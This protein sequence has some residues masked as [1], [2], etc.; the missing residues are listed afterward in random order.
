MKDDEPLHRLVALYHLEQISKSE[1]TELESRLR[2]S[3]EA[4]KVF[5]R[6][7]RVDAQLRQML[8]GSDVETPLVS[9]ATEAIRQRSRTVV[10]GLA[11]SV[12]LLLSTLAWM[13][14]S[15]PRAVATLISAENAA[16]ESSLPTTPGSQLAQ[17]SLKLIAGIATIRFD[18]GAEVVLE[19]PAQLDILSAMR[20]KLV[21]G[22]AVVD[23]P[24]TAIGFVMETPDS[25]AIDYGNRFAVQVDRA[26]RR[27][28]FELI[29]GEIAVHHAETGEELRMTEPRRTVSVHEGSIQFMDLGQSSNES[30]ATSKAIRIG[31]NG[32]ATSVLRNNK[33]R[34]FLDPEVLSVKKTN[35]GKWDQRSFFAFDLSSVDVSQIKAAWLRLNLVPSQRGFASRLPEVNRFG[36]YGLTN[37]TK[38]D[39]RIESTWEDAP[40]P[41][42]GTLLGTFEIA[43]SQQ[44][45]TFGIANRKVVEFLQKFPNETVHRRGHFAATTRSDQQPIL[46][47]DRQAAKLAFGRIVVDRDRTVIQVHHQ[48]VPLVQRVAN[49]LA[50]L[51]LGKHAKV[52]VLLHQ[53]FA[54]LFHDRQ[55]FP[56][57]K[58]KP[59][60]DRQR[61]GAIFDVIQATIHRERTRSGDPIVRFRFDELS[62]R[63]RIAARGKDLIFFAQINSFVHS[64]SID[65]RMAAKIF[66]E[67]SRSVPATIFGEVKHVVRGVF[68]A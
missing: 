43:R 47:A 60:L 48:L 67:L 32:R 13:Q 52:I 1:F 61:F 7:C 11:A 34:K 64:I 42:D 25:Y 9:V 33:R 63:V 10:V 68:L 23:V 26:D 37:H 18:S 59:I 3:G 36:V 29:E 58:R 28:N 17:G 6:S 39:W 27:A 53:P 16:W 45:G 40:G 49:R 21:D 14:V 5:H 38:A 2:D 4:R 41:E 55:R 8:D 51:T 54:K 50:E 62:A 30:E 19:A 20:G 46:P 12:M 44:R 65:R 35:T 66:Q 56:L 15:R 57:S 24:D 22:A 31:T